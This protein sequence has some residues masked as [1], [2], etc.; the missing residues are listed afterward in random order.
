MAPIKYMRTAHMELLIQ[1]RD[2][3]VREHQLRYTAYN[4]K[5]YKISLTSTCLGQCHGKQE[6]VL[7]SAAI[8]YAGVSGSLLL[9]LP[10][11][12]HPSATDAPR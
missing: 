2:G 1:W 3:A 4:G 6:G 10:S 12:S 11:G 8:Q 5:S 7:R 9:G